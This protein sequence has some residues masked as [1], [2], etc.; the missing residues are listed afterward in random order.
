MGRS[1]NNGT[2]T[3]T[4]VEKEERIPS[5][6]AF[7]CKLYDAAPKVYIGGTMDVGFSLVVIGIF[8]ILRQMILQVLY[9][10][11]W[12][13][14]GEQST[15][16]V[17]A[18]MLGGVFHTPLLVPTLFVLLTSQ[19]FDASA[20]MTSFPLWYQKTTSAM[21]QLC[22]GYMVYDFGITLWDRREVGLNDDDPMYM[23]HHFMTAFYMISTRMVG[24]GQPSAMISMFLGECTNPFFNFHLIFEM[25]VKYGRC[26]DDNGGWASKVQ[27]VVELLTA[28]SY[29][30]IRGL[31]A[32]FVLGI[33]TCSGLLFPSNK[34]IPFVLRIA[35]CLMIWAVLLGS[36]GWVKILYND[37]LMKYYTIGMQAMIMKEEL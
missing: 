11:G 28:V 36:I 12:P 27:I 7:W 34:Q 16:L 8:I 1:S 24:A 31:I 22:T 10:N 33:Y 17:G 25:A 19:P 30:S 35:Y 21:L 32:P 3:T 9:Y 37:T 6:A 18:C 5:L 20:T 26:C 23:A 2:T 4:T 29:V 13:S 14:G 15:L